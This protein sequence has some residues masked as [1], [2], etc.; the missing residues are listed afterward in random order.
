MRTR[1]RLKA[2]TR[3]T[4]VTGGRSSASGQTAQS[5]RGAVLKR[6]NCRLRSFHSDFGRPLNETDVRRARR[7]AR[8]ALARGEADE[9]ILSFACRAI[10]RD[11]NEGG[12]TACLLCGITTPKKWM[13]LP[14]HFLCSLPPPT[15]AKMLRVCQLCLQGEKRHYGEDKQVHVNCITHAGGVE[16]MGRKCV[17]RRRH[18][19]RTTGLRLKP[20]A[21][22]ATGPALRMCKAADCDTCGRVSD[23]TN[24]DASDEQAGAGSEAGVEPAFGA[25][26]VRDRRAAA[27]NASAV[28][29][30]DLS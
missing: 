13:N 24:K 23:A 28:A 5:V 9:D 30:D 6:L 26:G 3:T 12:V 2:S 29:L 11:A 15:T 17:A 19:E 7:A 25:P 4:R 14:Q 10:K 21:D 1:K 20:V 18:L 22:V 27:G 16:S 8:I